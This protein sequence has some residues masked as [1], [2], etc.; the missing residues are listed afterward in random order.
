MIY[1]RCK[2]GKRILS[3]DK[4]CS[5]CLVRYKDYNRAR[6]RDYNNYKRDGS[7]TFYNTKAWKQ[8]RDYTV[9]KYNNMCLCCLYHQWH[10]GVYNTEGNLLR[11]IHSG[12]VNSSDIIIVHHIVE[13]LDDDS[14]K[15]DVG[16]LICVCPSCHKQIH[17]KYLT[18]DKS[19]IQC[20][21]FELIN[22]Y[23]DNFIS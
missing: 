20:E 14:K 3:T 8:A 15:L 22:W 9:N 13:L 1:K 18:L 12:Y 7:H 23:E 6:Y 16:N 4:M 2:C 11:D 19:R 17:D 5:N 21:L 10:R